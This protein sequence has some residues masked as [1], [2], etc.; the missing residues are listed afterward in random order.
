[1]CAVVFGALIAELNGGLRRWSKLQP[2]APTA[3]EDGSTDA[4]T[5]DDLMFRLALDMM[6]AGLE[7][8]LAAGRGGR[9]G[10]ESPQ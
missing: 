2:A 8:R 5:D 4:G 7:S 9:S 3:G 6:I 10:S 1:V